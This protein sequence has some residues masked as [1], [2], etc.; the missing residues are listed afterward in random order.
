M[1][2]CGCAQ[3]LWYTGV[4]CVF[5]VCAEKATHAPKWRGATGW[6]GWV[7]VSCFLET[8]SGNAKKPSPQ[9]SILRFKFILTKTAVSIIFVWCSIFVFD[10]RCIT[11][12]MEDIC[13]PRMHDSATH[14]PQT[15]SNLRTATPAKTCFFGWDFEFHPLSDARRPILMQCPRCVPRKT[16]T[17]RDL[18]SKFKRSKCC[19]GGIISL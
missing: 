13:V 17:T 6:R 2:E 19:A 14:A 15:L 10:I 18:F 3:L 12:Y 1:N 9:W 16:T 4:W 11:Y 7:C 8:P 5:P